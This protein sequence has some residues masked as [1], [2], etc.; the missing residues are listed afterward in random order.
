MSVIM[1]NSGKFLW[2]RRISR[3]GIEILMFHFCTADRSGRG[4]NRLQGTQGSGEGGKGRSGEGTREGPEKEP[5][6]S[7]AH[8]SDPEAASGGGREKDGGERSC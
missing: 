2:I 5:P 4:S 8:L 1:G 6:A 7:G 3:M